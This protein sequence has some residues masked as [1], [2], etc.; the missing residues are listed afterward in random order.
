[1]DFFC[2][3]AKK[4]FCFFGVPFVPGAGA[5]IDPVRTPMMSGCKKRKNTQWMDSDGR[6]GDANRERDDARLER[7]NEEFGFRV[8]PR[9][10][11][12]LCENREEAP[13]EGTRATCVWGTV[14]ARACSFV[15]KNSVAF[16]LYTLRVVP[17]KAMSGW[18]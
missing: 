16:A 14:A 8:R 10:P 7:R 3:F 13:R 18:S 15:I 1:M 4:L 12:V 9:S 11:R 17:Y 2:A 6:P 5:F